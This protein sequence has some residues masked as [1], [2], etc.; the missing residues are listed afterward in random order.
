MKTGKDSV[1]IGNVDGASDIGERSVV[2]G[3]TDSHGNTIL[4]TPMAVGYAAKAGPRSIAIGAFAGAG[5]PNLSFPQQLQSEM[6]GIINLAVREG[7]Q[8]PCLLTL[9]KVGPNLALNAD[10]PRRRCAPSVVAP[11]SLV[12]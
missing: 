3:A 5:L 9:P 7:I 8:L 2:I 1:V 11:V 6:E 10:A 4:T 12:R